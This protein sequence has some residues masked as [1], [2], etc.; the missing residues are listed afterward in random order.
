[1]T[2][3]YQRT[4]KTVYSKRDD[5][6]LIVTECDELFYQVVSFHYGDPD[7]ESIDFGIKHPIDFPIY[8]KKEG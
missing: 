5:V 7:D 6:T 8:I 1:M 2:K 4:Y 3:E